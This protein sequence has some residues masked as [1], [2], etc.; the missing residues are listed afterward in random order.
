LLDRRRAI[1][2]D[3]DALLE[4]FPS[5]SV[6]ADDVAEAVR[7]GLVEPLDDGRV[8]VPDE[9]FLGTGGA[10]LAL[11]VPARVVLEEW[12]R[13][14]ASMDAVAERFVSVFETHLLPDRSRDGMDAAAVE[15]ATDALR[16]L[17]QV[18]RDVVLAALD[19]AFARAAAQRLDE[20]VLGAAADRELG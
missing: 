11:G 12:A 18:A 1:V 2:L 3:G 7:L 9:R 4:R 20:H 15:R 13:L 5:G 8:R 17:E 16:R 14:A 6:S 10:L 19:A